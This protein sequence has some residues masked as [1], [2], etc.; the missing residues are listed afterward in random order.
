MSHFSALTTQWPEVHEAA[1]R[2]EAQV[3]SD[4]RAACFYA[5]RALERAVAWLYQYDPSLRMPYQDNISAL[6]HEPTFKALVG[7]AL[8]TKARALIKLG[9]SA[10]HDTRSVTTDDAIASVR[11]LFHFSHWLSRTYSRRYEPSPEVFDSRELPKMVSVPRQTLEQLQH[12]EQSLASKDAEL[13]ATQA[14]QTTADEELQRLRAEIAAIKKTAEARPDDH[15]YNEAQTRDLFIDLLLHE[16]GWPLDQTQDREFEVTGMPN[17]KGLGYADYVL[18][19]DDGKPLGLVEAK[20]TRR[21]AKVGRQQAK[22]YADGLETMFGQRPV[23]FYT[24]G[25]EHWLWDDHSSPPRQ[26]QGFYKKDELEYMVRGR[27]GRASL[28]QVPVNE[29]IAGRPYQIRAIRRVAEAFEKQNERRALLVMATGAGKTRTVIGLCDLLMRSQWV[30]RVLFL[31]DRTALVNQAVTAFKKHL[32][33]AAPV[34]LVTEKD[35]SGRVFLSTYPTMMGLI[36]ET[37][38]G[39][40]RFGPG[41]FDLIVIDE[42]HR[43]VFQKYRAIFDYFDGLLVGL[44]ATPKDELDRNTYT[45]FNLENGVPTDAYSLEEAVNDE[46]LVPLKAVSVPLGFQRE[47]ITYDQLSEE[48]KDQWDEL[49]WDEGEPVPDRVEASAV[50]TWLFNTDTVDKVLEYLMTK[51]QKVAGGDRLGKTILFAKNQNHAEF[52]AQRF[53]ANYP[54]LKGWFARVITFKSDYAQS[55]IDEFSMREG[56]PHLAISVDLLDTG[57]DVPEVVNLV[58]FKLV[59]SKTKF[60]QMV[61]RGTRLCPDLFG[62]GRDKTHFL[63][64]DFCQNLEF[65]GQDPQTVDGAVSEGLSTRLFRGRVEVIG[66]L[67]KRRAPQIDPDGIGE[68]EFGF[69]EPGNDADV[70]R[71]TANLLQTTVASMNLNNFL[72]RK[73]RRLVEK[74]AQRSAWDQVQ[75]QDLIEI[76][77]SLADLPD[78]MPLEQEEAKRF[79]ILVLRTQLAALKAEPGFERLRDQIRAIAV[80]LEEKKNIPMV[81]HQLELILDIQQEEW[82]FDVSQAVLER[83]RRR[84]RDLVQFIDKKAR[85][86]V[87]TDFEDTLGEASEIELAGVGLGTDLQKF[88]AKA[89]AFLLD[90]QQERAVHKLRMN[91]PLTRADLNDLERVLLEANVATP[92]DLDAARADADGLG[93]FVRHLIGLD[94][95]AAKSAFGAFLEGK[96]WTANQIE[97]L[98][99]LINHLVNDGFVEPARMYESPFIDLA[100]KGPEGLFTDTQVDQLVAILRAVKETAQAA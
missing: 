39:Q 4:P 77:E 100:P 2:A 69:S 58:F 21:Y 22:L 7:E 72:V 89:R 16:A 53:D 74:Y 62:P 24:N 67:D 32:P 26:V 33:N 66:A 29:A 43:S 57:I 49:D 91:E 88:R 11:E 79:D 95:G 93:L 65:F 41:H 60:W 80:A 61:G 48:E 85:R 97:F 82:W 8:F 38:D 51:G 40:R 70:R 45:L 25:Y 6:I 64:F 9:N 44:T 15:D 76:S 35:A 23:V 92:A 98:D 83:L 84:L 52:I 75:N 14:A 94:R 81:A 17:Q 71:E 20:R 1:I 99:L 42:A 87:Y 13:V 54:T 56:A 86:I 63:I 46:Y 50:N 31:A 68:G 73:Q 96:T 36:D 18:W 47:G 59:R 55:V 19:G 28:A 34:N 10:V 27:T 37:R 5:R 3:H 12:L 30:K 78:G 90:H